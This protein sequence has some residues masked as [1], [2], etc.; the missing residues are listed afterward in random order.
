MPTFDTREPITAV[1][2]LVMGDVRISAGDRATTSVAVTP[3]DGANEDDVKAARLTV[4]EYGG[5]RLLVKAPELGL[6]LS[7]GGPG[8]VD[9][10]VELPAGSDV[11]VPRRPPT[12]TATAGWATAGSSSGSA[13]SGS[14]KSAS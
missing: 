11:I 3:S 9:V 12:S 7:R 14:T 4:V 1:L 6:L 8:S 13:P 10:A 2:A 5:G